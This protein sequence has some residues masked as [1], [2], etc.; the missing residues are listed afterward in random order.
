VRFE[1][2]YL[3]RVGPIRDTRLPIAPLTILIGGNG[4]GKT[5]ILDAI[6][7]SFNGT[8]SATRSS[9]LQ[10]G[11]WHNG[12]ATSI[13]G[14]EDWRTPGHF[15]EE[16]VRRTL[17]TFINFDAND[18]VGALPFL[19]PT[20]VSM[21]IEELPPFEALAAKCAG[22]LLRDEIMPPPGDLGQLALTLFS[23]VA[24]AFGRSVIR[25]S[26]PLRWGLCSRV[27]P[28]DLGERFQDLFNFYE[29]E[30]VD[31]DYHLFSDAIDTLATGGIPY[32]ASFELEVWNSGLNS[33]AL[34][35]LVRPTIHRL[36][37][38]PGTLAQE[39][40][41]SVEA[42]ANKLVHPNGRTGILG[43]VTLNG[44][45]KVPSSW[46]IPS[47][48]ANDRDGVAGSWRVA[49]G[50]IESVDRISRRVDEILPSFIREMA[51]VRLTLKPP[52][53]WTPNGSRVDIEILEGKRR[54]NSDQ[55]GA[56]T[57]RWISLTIRLA[58][59][60]LLA[61]KRVG[62]MDQ[63][64]QTGRLT[65]ADE[66]AN[67]FQEQDEE[68]LNSEPWQ[69]NPVALREIELDI[70]KSNTV[71]LIDE[72]EA[73]L[74]PRAV[75][76][77][78]SW[79]EETSSRVSAVVVAT[80]HPELINIHS[81][82]VQK[83][84]LSRI[85][86]KSEVT[87]WDGTRGSSLDSFAE[88]F[89]L[90]DSAILQMSRLMLFV[91]GP[92]D[93]IILRTF[94]GDVLDSGGVTVLVLHG[95]KNAS[96]ILESEVVAKIGIP[97]GVLADNADIE[98]VKGGTRTNYEESMIGRLIR[99]WEAAGRELRPFGLLR[100]DIIEYLDPQVCS[101][102]AKKP[103]RDWDDVRSR[104]EAHKK[105]IQEDTP[106]SKSPDFKKWVTK[107]Y[108]LALAR[109]NVESLAQE[110]RNRDLIPEAM[111]N[112]AASIIATATFVN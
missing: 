46:L 20:P 82:G 40:E 2:I 32:L 92:H 39:L 102:A 58:C 19:P 7:G 42:I 6:E 64:L 41:V 51:T 94:F 24:F 86:P 57:A 107:E 54:L 68:E 26:Y 53:N 73:H 18:P 104:Y 111:R 96:M 75:R 84:L 83:V 63:L 11:D 33:R 35:D 74:H 36:N 90:T 76:S 5:S 91:E 3:E 62:A 78:A 44:I 61:A 93:E 69:L 31:S 29:A 48:R 81:F 17:W 108:G 13:I 4:S 101:G 77:I 97:V 43:G 65:H 72:P 9:G 10:E 59:G 50:I 8:V 71:V 103:L 38:E 98:R 14:L 106:G 25:D 109:G 37:F 15:E 16:L 87:V 30:F 27:K 28:D 112:L 79:L 45:E 67:V 105:R 89:G 34:R 95:L 66:L 56:G 85:G 21:P 47:V 110:C 80:H 55:V 100:S 22:E 88:S 12:E 70:V 52:G 1:E 99:E 49:P 23:N 60:E